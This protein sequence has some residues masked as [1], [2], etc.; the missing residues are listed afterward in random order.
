MRRVARPECVLLLAAFVLA[1]CGS[2]ARDEFIYNRQVV[3]KPQRGDGSRIASQWNAPT[4][5]RPVAGAT[6]IAAVGE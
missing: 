5:S 3:I 6:P 2:T 4:P 1:G